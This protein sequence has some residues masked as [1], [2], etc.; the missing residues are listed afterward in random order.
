MP[1]FTSGPSEPQNLASSSSST[2][3]LTVNWDEPAD[4]NGILTDYSISWKRTDGKDSEVFK[5]LPNDTLSYQITGLKSNTEYQVTVYVRNSNIVTKQTE[6]SAF[7]LFIVEIIISSIQITYM[8]V[9]IHHD[10][11]SN[12]FIQWWLSNDLL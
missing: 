4:L 3:S 1:V 6:S 5:L 8:A 7:F 12:D 2:S 10:F 9:C 11:L